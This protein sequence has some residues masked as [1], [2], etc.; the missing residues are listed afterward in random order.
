RPY[1]GTGYD[2]SHTMGNFTVSLGQ[3]SATNAGGSWLSTT[4]AFGPASF[5]VSGW[6]QGEWFEVPLT[7]P[8]YYDGVSNV[9]LDLFNNQ[10]QTASKYLQ[11]DNSGALAY[12]N[13]SAIVSTA[14]Y[15]WDFGVSVFPG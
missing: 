11:V 6:K 12:G 5:T 4:T 1:N 13:S 8:F 15:T 14:T 10:A 9:V 3:T 2:G 7:T